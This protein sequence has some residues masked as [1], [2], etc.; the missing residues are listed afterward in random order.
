[1]MSGSVSCG[2]YMTGLTYSRSLWRPRWC[3]RTI[4]APSKVPPTLPSFARNSAMVF[5]FQSSASLMS[6]SCRS[7]SRGMGWDRVLDGHRLS[8]PLLVLPG[9]GRGICA[10]CLSLGGDAFCA[11]EMRRQELS[12]SVQRGGPFV[13]HCVEGLEDVR[14]PRGDVEGDLHVGDGGLPGEADGVVEENFVRSGLD[15]QRRQAGQVGEDRAD[16]AESGVVPRGVVG[17]RGLERF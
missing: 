10:C 14:H 17:G 5:A 2:R 3:T 8:G 16:E 6:N 12:G 7:R 4:G 11:G 15:D 9:S 13:E 1:M